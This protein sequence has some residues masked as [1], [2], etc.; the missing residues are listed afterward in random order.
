MSFIR[1]QGKMSITP[2][3]IGRCTRWYKLHFLYLLETK[4]F[5]GMIPEKTTEKEILSYLQKYGEITEF[6]II[7]KGDKQNKGYGFCHF[8]NRAQ[9]IQAIK[10]MNGKTFLH[11]YNEVLP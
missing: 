11:V 1:K 3:I 7:K 2:Y 6:V 5:I 10:G 9:A 8:S 4:L